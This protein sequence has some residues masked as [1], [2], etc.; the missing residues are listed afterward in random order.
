[1][2]ASKHAAKLVWVAILSL[3]ACALRADC[4]HTGARPPL[5][6][7]PGPSAATAHRGSAQRGSRAP[8][9]R[10]QMPYKPQAGIGTR[11]V[12]E[13]DDEEARS[14]NELKSVLLEALEPLE[15]GFRADA[16]Q[17][18]EIKRLMNQLALVSPVSDPAARLLGG[19]SSWTLIYSDAPDIVGTGTGNGGLLVPQNGRIGQ[20]IEVLGL[21]RTITNLVEIKPAGIL[22]PLFPRDVLLLRVLLE[23]EQLSETMVG[24]KLL[25]TQAK[26]I[27]L[28]NVD[29]PDFFPPLVNV[30]LPVSLT[31]GE[32]EIKYYDSDMR[33][34]RT[35]QGFYFIAILD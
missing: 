8:L 35:G 17:R 21:T 26:P 19:N 2:P 9:L 12:A 30:Q 11:W 34:V 6:A 4:L 13:A 10:M 15:R 29:V 24:L 27:T 5:L 3:G 7:H 23:A 32:F 28:A 14:R 22:S 20:D 31:F 16:G 25:G 33:I 18:K 1:M